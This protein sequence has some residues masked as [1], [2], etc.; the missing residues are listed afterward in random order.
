MY[1]F[2]F[3]RCL[4]LL[5]AGLAIVPNAYADEDP[6]RVAIT[7]ALTDYIDGS[8]HARPEWLRRAFHPDA[9]LQLSRP[10]TDYWSV[11]VDEYVGR[12]SGW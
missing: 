4:V 6:E 8:A 3:L 12:F 9:R 5:L 1:T 2:R 10:G 11:S 7:R